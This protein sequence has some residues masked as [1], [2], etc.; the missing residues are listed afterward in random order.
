[1]SGKDRAQLRERQRAQ[2]IERLLGPLDN[3]ASSR[4]VRRAA[5][6]QALRPYWFSTQRPRKTRAQAL[7]ERSLAR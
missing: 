3:R 4:Q 6:R 5:G 2:F 1:M 7:R